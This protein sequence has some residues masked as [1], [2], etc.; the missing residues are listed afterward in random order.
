VVNAGCLEPL[1]RRTQGQVEWLTAGG[2]P[3]GME[4][5]PADLRRQKVETTL[6]NGDMVIFMTDGVVEA[7]NKARQMLGFNSLES[8]VATG[9]YHSAE[10]MKLHILDKVEAHRGAAEQ[11]DDVTIVV[12]RVKENSS[13]VTQILHQ[14]FE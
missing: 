12:V 11:D 3:L 13:H 7:K 6:R 8:I 4:V 1:I 5:T 10:A 14:P 2:L 9:P